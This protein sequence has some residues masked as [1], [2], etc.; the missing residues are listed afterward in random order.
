V[1]HD[2]LVAFEERLRK[3]R[4]SIRGSERVNKQAPRAEAEALSVLWF[5]SL[6]PRIEGLGSAS[7]PQVADM[8]AAMGKL[9]VLSRPNNRASSYE[10]ALDAALSKFKDR[11][12]KPIQLA[13]P[14]D[15]TNVVLDAILKKIGDPDESE[16]LSEAIACAK[17]GRWRASVVM[18]WCAA[19]DRLQQTVGRIGFD[20]FNA[21][22]TRLKNKTTGK[23]KN[24]TKGVQAGSLS[25]LQAVFDTDLLAVLEEMGLIDSN[26]SDRLKVCFQYRNQSAHPAKPPILDVHLAAFYTD[27]E[28][29]IF[30]NPNFAPSIGGP[31]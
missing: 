4:A 28:A 2:D 6:K 14:E 10:T 8:T 3:L 29:I 21:A 24:W 18:G 16:Y 31:A 17:D 22:S 12:L 5:T 13:A 26:E 1:L 11:F 19:I 9:H 15:K 7:A 23:Y 20:K 27:I 25:E 30:S